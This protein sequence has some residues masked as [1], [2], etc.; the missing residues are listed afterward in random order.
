MRRSRETSA[1]QNELEARIAEK[2]VDAAYDYLAR[3]LDDKPA[4]RGFIQMALILLVASR[5]P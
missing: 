2:D 5:R 4:D 3:F 1:E